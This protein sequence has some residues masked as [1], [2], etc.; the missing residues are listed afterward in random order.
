[1]DAVEARV[2][3]LAVKVGLLEHRLAEL[4]E[5]ATLAA[6]KETVL[7]EVCWYARRAQHQTLDAVT[8]IVLAMDLP[9]RWWHG[10]KGASLGE[11]WALFNRPVAQFR[12]EHNIGG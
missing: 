4:N 6:I 9:G 11:W 12:E 7:T 1:M 3:K 10:Y 2:D 5:R 8:N